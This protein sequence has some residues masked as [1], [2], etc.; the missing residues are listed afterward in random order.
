MLTLFNEGKSVDLRISLRNHIFQKY[1]NFTKFDRGF[2]GRGIW[3]ARWFLELCE[4][5]NFVRGRVSFENT[6][7]YKI[8]PQDF[9]R[10][11]ESELQHD[12]FRFE[13][14]R[15]NFIKYWWFLETTFY[16]WHSY[17][18]KFRKSTSGRELIDAVNLWSHFI[19]IVIFVKKPCSK[20]K[21]KTS[22]ICHTL[23][24]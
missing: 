5:S 22:C 10:V 3:M 16:H 21:M 2:W 24:I 8:W 13:D 6:I 1:R 23:I 11:E 7:F 15:S 20:K 19:Y 4:L 14:L 12:F 9:Y 18:R 17:V